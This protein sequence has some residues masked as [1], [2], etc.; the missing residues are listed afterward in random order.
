[1]NRT[2]LAAALVAIL[3]CGVLATVRP[4][5]AAIATPPVQ[6]AGIAGVVTDD[7]GHP[8]A[9]VQVAAQSWISFVG[10]A[11]ATTN[12]AGEFTLH[13]G[14]G[15]F[16][17]EIAAGRATGG[18]SDATGYYSRGVG[19]I[20]VPVASMQTGFH[21]RLQPAGAVVGRVEDSAGHGLSGVATALQPVVDYVT[22]DEFGGDTVN[23]TF[24]PSRHGWFTITGVAPGAYQVCTQA[25]YRHV[26]GGVSDKLGYTGQCRSGAVSVA[27]RRR[28]TVGRTRLSPA[29]GG[30]IA[31]RVTGYD[32]A[33]LAHLQVEV[34]VA[35]Y[36]AVYA[37]TDADGR[38]WVHGLSA[39]THRVCFATGGLVG[40][41]RTGYAPSCRS[42]VT[43]HARRVHQLDTVLSAGAAVTGIVS[44]A[45]RSALSGAPVVVLRGQ[46]AYE[47]PIVNTNDSGRYLVRNLA[48]S[49]E[50][51]VCAETDFSTAEG[52]HD[53]TG[54]APTCLDRNGS[55]LTLT[56]GTT[57]RADLALPAA[58]GV[59]GTITKPDGTPLAGVEV[60]LD[61]N[62]QYGNEGEF[63]AY[64]DK[65]GHYQAL[66][67]P[68]VKYEVCFSDVYY[69]EKCYKT[70]SGSKEIKVTGGAFVDGI[71]TTLPHVAPPSTGL[72]VVDAHHRR[73]AGVDAVLYK[74]CRSTNKS[75]PPQPLLGGRATSHDAVITDVHGHAVLSPYHPGTYTL[76][77]FAYYGAAPAV[78]DR[79]GYAD[80]CV[81]KRV[82]VPKHG[83]GRTV[84]VTLQ[85]AGAVS[86]IVTNAHGKPLA[87]T[88]IHV[89]GSAAEHVDTGADAGRYDTM[90]PIQDEYTDANG[91]FLIRS[92][93][94]GTWRVTGAGRVIVRAGRITRNV[95][96]TLTGTAA[97]A[98]RPR[99][100]APERSVEPRAQ[101]PSANRLRTWHA[102]RPAA[103][104]PSSYRDG[105]VRATGTGRPGSRP[106]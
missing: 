101:R 42:G 76:C 12:A 21:V 45:N 78:A 55:G 93:T 80:K 22:G 14:P 67:L 36:D 24:R 23:A 61:G 69:Y 52:T 44:G 28:T 103:S 70:P 58:G 88:R 95:H 17:L 63:Y 59:R 6:H 85:R 105:A 48:S 26:T 35:K 68:P 18:D 10:G 102:V 100:A 56:S 9:G 86:G 73:V 77:L 38:Y 98:A 8:L 72:V 16:Y 99:I 90:S 30:V 27:S 87:Y 74:K 106:S 79:I 82:V 40:R 62:T 89:A 3:A 60:D 97:R 20:H 83:T 29:G 32:H 57:T 41:S 104:P 49:R 15:T 11:V 53:P 84:R 19:N 37:T 94:P 71:D 92:V 25:A 91:R 13:T 50:Y 34:R 54:G 66:D 64:T 39:G 7:A 4:S 51:D 81:A 5:P 46:G 2:R 47:G 31:G 96:I 33:P 75:C 43:V 1:M 65:H